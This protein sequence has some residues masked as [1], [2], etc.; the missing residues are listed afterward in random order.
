[1]DE[2][3]TRKLQA[4]IA[5]VESSYVLSKRVYGLCIP[6]S[7]GGDKKQIHEGRQVSELDEGENCI[8]LCVVQIKHRK[9]Q[10]SPLSLPLG[11][12]PSM[13][14]IPGTA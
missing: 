4:S 3:K 8:D 1:M 13:A 7:V 10:S 11:P 5:F 2:R 12:C 9:P 6:D 14:L